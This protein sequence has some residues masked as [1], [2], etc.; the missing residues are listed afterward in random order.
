MSAS[1][2]RAAAAAGDLESFKQGVPNPEIADEMFAAVRAGMGIKDKEAVPAEGVAEASYEGNIG[3]MEL[4]K[5]FA[6]AEK[7]DPQLVA[8]VKQLIKQGEDKMVWGIVQDYTSTKLVGK[9]FE[10]S[11]AEAII[12][13]ACK[14]RMKKRRG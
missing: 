5:F 8:K 7:E 14:S 9:E 4:F 2:M 12:E 6:K 10:G 1:K 13:R 3:I 11:I